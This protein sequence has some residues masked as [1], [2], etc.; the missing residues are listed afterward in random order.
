MIGCLWVLFH[1]ERW[2]ELLEG[3]VAEDLMCMW[4]ILILPWEKVGSCCS[5]SPSYPQCP[6]HIR[7]VNKGL[8]MCPEPSCQDLQLCHKRNHSVLKRQTAWVD[9]QDRLMRCNQG[10]SNTSASEFMTKLKSSIE[11]PLPSLITFFF[12]LLWSPL[13]QVPSQPD[14]QVKNTLPWW[15]DL[16]WEI[17]RVEALLWN[18]VTMWP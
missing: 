15:M 4:L 18:L 1:G 13:V 7:Q 2:L 9:D 16:H 8:R 12:F 14:M 10:V 5:P 17:P 6:V 3:R 11:K